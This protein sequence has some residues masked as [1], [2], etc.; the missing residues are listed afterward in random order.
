METRYRTEKRTKKK[1]EWFKKKKKTW[2]ESVPYQVPTF[3]PDINAL[4]NVF[5]TQAMN[6]WMTSFQN[7]VD[8]MTAKIS[9]LVS[10]KVT[11]VSNNVLTSAEQKVQSALDMSRAAE[12][13][14]RKIANSLM[15][16]QL[17]VEEIKKQFQ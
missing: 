8:A 7:H 11:Q 9:R 5:S 17:K 13:N 6:P 16:S 10:G 12:H 2:Y 14:A 1:R 3:G 15:T 4:M